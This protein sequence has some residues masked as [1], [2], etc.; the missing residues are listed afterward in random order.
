MRKKFLMLSAWLLLV[1]V[2][3]PSPAAPLAPVAGRVVKAPVNVRAGAGMDYTIVGKLAMN[4]PVAI[5]AVGKEWLEI[6]PPENT[7]VWALEQYIRNRKFTTNANLRAGPGIGYET[8]G[9]ARAGLPVATVGQ[10]TAAGWIMIQP[11]YWM[12]VYVGRGAI[13]ADAAELARLPALPGER[14][15]LPMKELAKLEGNF[16]RAGQAVHLT[17]YLYPSEDRKSAV[18]HVLYRE[19]GAELEP[20][21]FVVSY[22][23]NLT[24]FQE[25]KVSISGTQY[26]VAN[27]DLPVVIAFRVQAVK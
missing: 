15:P 8:L 9:T 3:L 27:W 7:A 21:A 14:K 12:R 6:R 1:P 2:S 23:L 11:Y 24:G 19:K 10:A 22:G 17:G 18:T 16:T 20:A 25:K 4:N 26:P 13:A 5:T